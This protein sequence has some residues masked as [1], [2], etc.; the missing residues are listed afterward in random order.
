MEEKNVSARLLPP[1]VGK[2]KRQYQALSPVIEEKNVS[3]KAL[4]KV[5]GGKNVSTRL[6]P[7]S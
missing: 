4:C 1:V 5:I 2:E 7:Q 6:F 3:R